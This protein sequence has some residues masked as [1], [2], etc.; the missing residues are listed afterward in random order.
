MSETKHIK[1]KLKILDIDG[2]LEEKCKSVCETYGYGPDF[3]DYE[4]YFD[5]VSN[6]V[7][8]FFIIVDN[9]IYEI[10]EK[11]EP[12]EYFTNVFEKDGIIHF[13]TRFYNGSCSFEESLEDGLKK[14][15]RNRK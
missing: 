3:S 11:I 14:L 9:D 6:E 4:S 7:Y 15:K 10:M 8:D 13:E 2:T 1:G 12:D 5:F